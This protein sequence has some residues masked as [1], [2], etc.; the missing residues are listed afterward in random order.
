[1]LLKRNITINTLKKYLSE[2]IKECLKN[3]NFPLVKFNLTMCKNEEFGDLS[4]NIAMLLTKPINKKPID[5]ADEIKFN[6]LKN[7]NDNIDSITVTAPGFINFKIK[8]DFYQNKIKQVIS[9]GH[10]FGKPNQKNVKT[11]NIEFVSANPTGPLTVGHGR[12][13]VIGDSVSNILEWHGYK[14]TREYYYNNAGKQ[15]RMLHKSV[16]SRYFELINKPSPFPENGY[17]GEYI[18]DIAKII[19]DKYGDKLEKEDSKFLLE[20][21]K[22]IFKQIEN[23][24]LR[25]GI[26]FDV[27]SNEKS[28]YD[29]GAIKKLLKELKQKDLIYEKDGATWFRATSLNG[30]QDKVYIKSS[31]EPTYRLPDT[32]YHRDKIQRGFDL[33]VDVFGADH[34]DTYPDILSALKSL[35]LNTN[36][37]KIL[38]YQFVT[39]I[40]NKKKVKMS[41][42][43]ADFITL[44]DLI[45]ELGID[46]VRYFFIMRSMNSH[47]DFDLDLAKDQ[48]DNNPVYY[49]QYAHAR[50]C[51]VIMHGLN[52]GFTLSNEFNASLLNHN[53]ELKLMKQISNFPEIMSTA[54][55]TLEP[56]SI[57]NYLQSLASQFHK[58]YGNCKIITDD[59]K[60]SQSR[61]GLAQSVKIILSSGLSILGISAPEKM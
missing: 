11:A 31:G 47:L 61:L 20:A 9:D 33:I 45:D 59:K 53:N 48:S 44:D 56:Q 14:V 10:N 17:Q 25:L 28:F 2:E 52:Q 35:D 7:I 32:A 6:L 37:I 19:L 24:L 27:Y 23:S 50:I 51:N 30:K 29:S 3:L 41:T 46:I 39:L 26:K 54:L 12:N 43:K 57:A 60:L 15:M 42:R 4:T 13:A 36:H 55:D 49:L 58:F 22:N 1:M 21:E 5:I 34:T 8:Y 40:K 38:I 16:S 18:I